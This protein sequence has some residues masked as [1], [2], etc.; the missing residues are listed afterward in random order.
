MRLAPSESAAS[1]L[2]VTS[3]GAPAARAR[4]IAG[5]DSGSTLTIFARVA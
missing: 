2:T 4:C 5:I 3:T 1:P